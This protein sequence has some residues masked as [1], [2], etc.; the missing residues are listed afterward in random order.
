MFVL[1]FN[2]H[3]YAFLLFEVLTTMTTTMMMMIMKAARQTILHIH[4]S[5]M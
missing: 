1:V 5:Q 2:Q 4:H 3:F